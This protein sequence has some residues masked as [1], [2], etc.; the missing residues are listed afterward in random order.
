MAYTPTRLY[1][2]TPGTTDTLLATVTS[3]KT[4]IVK[5]ILVT[6]TTGTAATITIGFDASTA[7][8]ASNH[9][10]S[11]VTIEAN[12]VVQFTMA[13]VLTASMTIRGLQGTAS[14]L[15]VLISGAEF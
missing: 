13:Q 9:V 3:G 5:D 11:G 7:L 15:N 4:W 2:G 8:A 6:N 14:S 1:R 10:I 12:E